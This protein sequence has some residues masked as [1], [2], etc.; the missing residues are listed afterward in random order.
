MTMTYRGA[1]S[2][3]VFLLPFPLQMLYLT[4]RMSMFRQNRDVILFFMFK[5]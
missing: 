5:K 1:F 2:L 4:A 3:N